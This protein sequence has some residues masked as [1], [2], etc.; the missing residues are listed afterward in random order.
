MHLCI[1]EK[2]RNRVRGKFI[3]LPKHLLI[4]IL[5]TDRCIFWANLDDSCRFL[6]SCVIISPVTLKNMG[7]NGKTI[8][9]RLQ[10]SQCLP[11]VLKSTQ[12]FL[13]LFSS[14]C[15]KQTPQAS[16]TRSSEWAFKKYWPSFVWAKILKEK[17]TGTINVLHH[18][19]SWSILD[20]GCITKLNCRED[21]QRSK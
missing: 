10:A 3:H 7:V 11:K 8:G 5:N 2:R 18:F 6:F 16:A 15:F 1:Q 20:V 14:P 19:T 4:V 9:S 13:S 17:T 21:G 12:T